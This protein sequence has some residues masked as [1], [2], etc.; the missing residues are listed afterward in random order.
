MAIKSCTN[1]RSRSR[2]R[3]ALSRNE[4]IRTLL[5]PVLSF[6]AI[7]AALFSANA[8]VRVVDGDTIEFD[9]SIHRI[10]GIDAP[11]VGQ[12]CSGTKG[13]RWPCGKSALKAMEDLVLP[14]TKVVC[15]NRG[16]DGYGRT[17]SVCTADGQDIGRMLVR[18]GLAWSFRK[19]AHDYDRDEDA[20]RVARL[21]VWQATNEAP[22]DYRAARWKVAVQEAPDRRCPIKGNI[23]EE[24]E[25]IY[26][27]PWSPWYSKTKVDLGRGERWFCDEA[28]AQSSG[29]RAPYWGRSK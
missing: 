8:G 12:E 7:A 29:W 2:G 14:A 20:A 27:A 26:H 25:R 18:S 9:G 22:W 4:A 13:N 21:G 19:Y 24:G 6:L 10:H 28:E 17:L 5:P 15:D 16:Q 3:S 1:L 23:S 11:E